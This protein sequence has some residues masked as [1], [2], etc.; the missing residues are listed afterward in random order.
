MSLIHP[1]THL[2]I[3]HKRL[4]QGKSHSFIHELTLAS[5]SVMCDVIRVRVFLFFFPVNQ[6]H[7]CSVERIFAFFRFLIRG[8]LAIPMTAKEMR[9]EKVK[10]ECGIEWNPDNTQPDTVKERDKDQSSKV[11][12]FCTCTS[13]HDDEC[14]ARLIFLAG[15]PRRFSHGIVSVKV[16]IKAKKGF[17][18]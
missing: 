3:G 13:K 10:K 1:L 4:H 5:E 7:Q 9:N 8:P 15:D 16:Q 6:I 11:L 12:F 14:L 17:T 2:G 18:H